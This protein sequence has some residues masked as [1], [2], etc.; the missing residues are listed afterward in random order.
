MPTHVS[1]RKGLSSSARL[2]K[3]HT[4]FT[5][6]H[7]Y[8]NTH[9]GIH[10]QTYKHLNK[11]KDKQK[12]IHTHARERVIFCH[13]VDRKQ[14]LK[15]WRKILSATPLRPRSAIIIFPVNIYDIATTNLLFSSFGWNRKGKGR[16]WAAIQLFE[17]VSPT[18]AVTPLVADSTTIN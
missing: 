16:R 10:I 1:S 14:V 6:V 3:M 5:H 17:S 8:I 12:H 4:S 2:N 11:K 15:L 7:D 9:R 13:K 18:T